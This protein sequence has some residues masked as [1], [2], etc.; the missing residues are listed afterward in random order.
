MRK[1]VRKFGTS[2][3]RGRKITN[4]DPFLP[5]QGTQ[6]SSFCTSCNAVYHRK[7]WSNDLETCQQ[8][9]SH[10]AT[11]KVTCPACR[12]IASNY[13]EGIVTLTGS[14]LWEHEAEIQQILKKEEDRAFAKNPQER[15]I[16]MTKEDGRLTIE[17]TEEKLAE[18]LGRVL[19]RAHRGELKISWAGNPDICRVSWERTL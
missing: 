16:R 10:S 4:V 5:H 15:I 14:Y 18:H 2:D 7:R 6:E 8:L 1:D 9:K 13:P 11:R 12:K 3:K 17:T 19:Q